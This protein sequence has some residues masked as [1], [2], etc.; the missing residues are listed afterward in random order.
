MKAGSLTSTSNQINIS[1]TLESAVGDQLGNGGLKLLTKVDGLD[2]VFAWNYGVCDAE[3]VGSSVKVADLQSYLNNGEYSKYDFSGVAYDSADKDERNLTLKHATTVDFNGLEVETLDI[4]TQESGTFV[5]DGVNAKKITVN[6]PNADIIIKDAVGEIEVIEVNDILDGTLTLENSKVKT[7]EVKD[8]N[9]GAIKLGS[10][11]VVEEFIVNTT[12]EITLTLG[13]DVDANVALA[14]NNSTGSVTLNKECTLHVKVEGGTVKNGNAVKVT[15]GKDVDSENVTIT[16]DASGLVSATDDSGASVTVKAENEKKVVISDVKKVDG[17]DK[18][19]T[20][21]AKP[22]ITTYTIIGEANKD[23]YVSVRVGDLEPKFISV[24]NGETAAN[25]AEAIAK[26]TFKGYKV[27]AEEG[28]LTFTTLNVG[29]DVKG[30]PVKVNFGETGLTST[31]SGTNGVQTQG[32]DAVLDSTKGTASFTVSSTGRNVKCSIVV[33][34]NDST[35]DANERTFEVSV[36]AFD[37]IKAIIN[38]FNGVEAF[39][40]DGAFNDKYTINAER[41]EGKEGTT[42]KVTISTVKKG[43]TDATMPKVTVKFDAK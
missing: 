2:G 43:S 7:L 29:K 11:A 31:N 42:C 3:T 14:N 24:K 37:D 30:F 12:G 13:N 22:A 18:E 26:L 33:T 40:E 17:K 5:V 15:L 35:I 19:I 34:I 1:K 41:V 6:A 39:G 21:A 36:D 10:D 38:A 20:E 27:E 32:D 16:Q 25:V 4:N 28:K 9:K 23:D 8:S